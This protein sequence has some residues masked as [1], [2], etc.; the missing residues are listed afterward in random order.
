MFWN[1]KKSCSHKCNRNQEESEKDLNKIKMQ[2]NLEREAV[3]KI[4]QD[5]KLMGELVEQERTTLTDDE[6]AKTIQVD[7]EGVE[8]MEDFIKKNLSPPIDKK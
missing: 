8:D 4:K 2:T 5:F 7:V 1:K 6:I 3:K